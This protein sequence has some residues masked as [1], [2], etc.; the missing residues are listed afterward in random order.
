M[1]LLSFDIWHLSLNS[2]VKKDYFIGIDIGAT[3][4]KL[5][6]VDDNGKIVNQDVISTK[7][8]TPDELLLELADIINDFDFKIKGVGIG[9]AGPANVKEGK[10]YYFVN[11]PGWDNMEVAAKFKLLT[12]LDTYVD[13]DVN[14]MAL[15]EHCYGAGVNY[16]N[17]ICLTLGSGVGG[18][19][20][21]DNSLYRGN[22]FVAGEIGHIPV[23]PEG[24]DCRCGGRGC[25]ERYVGNE[26]IVERAINK[27]ENGRQSSIMG[28]VRGDKSKITPRIIDEAY[29][30]GDKLAEEIWIETGK[31]IGIALVGVVNL[32]NPE[33]II[34]G[35][36]IA[37][38]GDILFNTIYDIIKQRAMEIHKRSIKVIPAKL[39]EVAGI[40]GAA[41]LARQRIESR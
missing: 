4:T 24:Y 3:N 29:R 9:V 32:F 37:K 6:V 18:G 27:I 1:V 11:S 33:I 8:Y 41:M 16:R 35:G 23:V 22:D 25:L 21:L 20:I 31:F 40:I 28:L 38:T 10:V 36:G 19:I 7:E 15:A 17:I 30:I 39:G 2:M 26:F 13:N 5:G 12:K 14:V 34:I